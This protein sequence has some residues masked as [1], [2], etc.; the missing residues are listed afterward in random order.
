MRTNWVYAAVLLLCACDRPLPEA[1]ACDSQLELPSGFCARVFA[2]EVGVARHI[3]V[4]SN[5]DVYVALEDARDASAGTTHVRGEHANG[6][7]L[8]LRDTTGDGRADVSL[9]FGAEGG[10]GLALRQNTLFFSSPTTVY[11]FQLKQDGMGPVDSGAIVVSGL[12]PGGHS[13]RSLALGEGNALFVNVGSLGN[14][15]ASGSAA[16]DPCMQLEQRAGIWQFRAD[17]VNQTYQ[18]GR[19]F[20]TGI[21]N[22][23]GLT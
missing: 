13:S 21:R 20:A 4:A 17:T 19:R 23:V 2:D 10:S 11:R 9:R 1:G 18:T 8:V 15:C 14:V 12:Q 3:A 22:A 5:G 16:E 6:G 7:V